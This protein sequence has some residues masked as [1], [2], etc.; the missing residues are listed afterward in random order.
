MHLKLRPE[1]ASLDIAELARSYQGGRNPVL[2]SV[3]ALTA[4]AF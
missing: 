2:L 1:I 3:T 4:Q